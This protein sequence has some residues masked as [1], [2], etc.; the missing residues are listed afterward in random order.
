MNHHMKLRPLPFSQMKEGTKTIELRLH[1]EK[2]RRIHPGDT[3]TFTETDSGEGLTVRVA[4]LH[5][6]PS[7]ADLF[8]A[9]GTERCGGRVDMD[10]YYPPE[11][12]RRYGVLGIEIT[13]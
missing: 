5:P 10:A 4:A 13:T 8:A 9:L 1:D 7:F 11:D 6:Y 3:I 12:Q 2:R